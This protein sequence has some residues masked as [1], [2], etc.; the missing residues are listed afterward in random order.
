[1]RKKNYTE[2]IGVL[3]TDEMY[4]KIVQITDAKEIP[5]SQFIREIVEE[6]INQSEEEVLYNE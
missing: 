3:L 5:L 2:L 6:K 1:M 4:N